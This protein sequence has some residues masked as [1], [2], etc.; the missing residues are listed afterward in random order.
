MADQNHA[1]VRWSWWCHDCTDV[2]TPSPSKAASRLDLTRHMHPDRVEPAHAPAYTLDEL[3]MWE[4]SC[5]C[6]EHS[7]P[8][9]HPADWRARQSY[10]KHVLHTLLAWHDQQDL[11]DVDLH[12]RHADYAKRFARLSDYNRAAHVKRVLGEIL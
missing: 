8:R 10:S 12:Q 11:R 4:W 1:K 3:G 7:Q 2:G 5:V 6:G 9:G